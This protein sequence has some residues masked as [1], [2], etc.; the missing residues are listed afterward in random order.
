MHRKDVSSAYA[1]ALQFVMRSCLSPTGGETAHDT[2]TL[3]C[4]LVVE[5]RWNN[6]MFYVLKISITYREDNLVE[7]NT[8]TV[9]AEFIIC[10]Y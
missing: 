5:M 6:Y 7:G 8:S 9:I 3:I 10:W 4:K 1:Y 2:K